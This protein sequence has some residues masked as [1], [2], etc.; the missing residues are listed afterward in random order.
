MCLSSYTFGLR[1]FN[2]DLESREQFDGFLS[3]WF[4]R[5]KITQK[6]RKGQKKKNYVRV[7]QEL[8]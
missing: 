7:T 8:S 2:T 6:L 5:A 1:E 3:I 4:G